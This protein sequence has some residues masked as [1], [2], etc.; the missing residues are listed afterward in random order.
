MKNFITAD[1]ENALEATQRKATDYLKSEIAHFKSGIAHFKVEVSN[2][3]S[4]IAHFKSEVSDGSTRRA[5]SV[6]SPF[7][8]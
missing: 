6:C 4:G 8:C 2:F 3:K 1:M 5:A 7:R